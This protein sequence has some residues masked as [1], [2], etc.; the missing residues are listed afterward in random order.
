MALSGIEIAR[1]LAESAQKYGPHIPIRGKTPM[2]IFD[3][4]AEHWY[5]ST[6][7]DMDIREIKNRKVLIDTQAASLPLDFKYSQGR[8]EEWQ[9]AAPP[10]I[11]EIHLHI[12]LKLPNR[13][14]PLF[15]AA[16]H[17]SHQYDPKL[18]DDS[19]KIQAVTDIM[20]SVTVPEIR[21]YII[22][23]IEHHRKLKRLEGTW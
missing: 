18:T 4:A 11:V 19:W 8:T 17:M 23:A 15:G 14:T 20:L 6:A 13:I 22:F 7:H 16:R 10:V 21:R 2:E 9:A 5:K 1:R 12:R 3:A